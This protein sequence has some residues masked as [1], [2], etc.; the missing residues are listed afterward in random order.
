MRTLPKAGSLRSNKS[1]QIAASLPPTR[2]AQDCSSENIFRCPPCSQHL[3]GSAPFAVPTQNTRIFLKITYQIQVTP[4]LQIQPDCQPISSP[5]GGIPNPNN[6]ALQIKN[7]AV[8]GFQTGVIF[9]SPPGPFA[10][11]IRQALSPCD[12]GTAK[13]DPPSL[14][15]SYRCRSQSAGYI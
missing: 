15:L 12:E 6:P 2:L 3:Y 10:R 11:P 14:R 13:N 9:C 8:F 1:G 4:W 7:D 5:G